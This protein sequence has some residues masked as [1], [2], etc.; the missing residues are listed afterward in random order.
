MI[1]H[2]L[3]MREHRG[4]I[5]AVILEHCEEDLIPYTVKLSWKF[6]TEEDATQAFD[7]FERCRTIPAEVKLNTPEQKAAPTKRKTAKRK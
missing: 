1:R 3:V 5:K 7:T 6:N 2:V 4:P